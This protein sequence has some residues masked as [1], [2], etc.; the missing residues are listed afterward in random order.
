MFILGLRK[1]PPSPGQITSAGSGLS[2][3]DV[4]TAT[5]PSAKPLPPRANLPWE[6]AILRKPSIGIDEVGRG[7]WAG[8]L[9]VVAARQFGDLPTGVVDSKL[10]T[11]AKRQSLVFDI[12]LACEIGEGWVSPVEIDQSGLSNGMRLGVERALKAL[13]AEPEEHIIIDGNINYCPTTY[14]NSAA[15]IN[16]DADY[17]VVSAA[18]IVA[19]VGRDNYMANAAKQ[20]PE[21]GFEKHVGYGTRMHIDKL[22]LHGTCALHRQS[23]K[24]IKALLGV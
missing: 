12:M 18:S 2:S 23:Y 14:I 22:K 8:P 10:L 9:L 17:P 15:V 7:C 13:G 24:P 21:Y 3:L 4:A 11:K 5:S 16:A 6:R 19:K 1:A 20:F